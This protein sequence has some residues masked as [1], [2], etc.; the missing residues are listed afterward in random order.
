MAE[1]I[2]VRQNSRPII[3][4]ILRDFRN[5]GGPTA[6]LDITGFAIRFIVKP[7]VDVPDAQAFFDLAAT[8]SDPTAGEYTLTLLEAHTALAP[9]S[10]PGE[11]RW[12]SGGV[13]T[14]PPTDAIQVN[15]VVQRAID[16]VI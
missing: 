7:N 3:K 15:Y 13:T 12:W 14:V 6:A 9:N 1:T 8:L 4:R 10:Y 11:I 5:Q 16:Q 2:S